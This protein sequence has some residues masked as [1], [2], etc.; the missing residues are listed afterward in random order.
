LAETIRFIE[1]RNTM[2][3]IKVVEE[4]ANELLNLMGTKAKAKVSEDKE[5]EA[6][7]VD[8]GASEEMGL[9][10]GHH[11]ET[12]SSFQ[13]LLGMILRQKTGE[14]TRVI[15]NVGDWR[16]KQEDYLRRLA[17]QTAQR[18]KETSQEQA[19]YNLSPSQR[20]IIHIAL[21]SDPDLETESLG[22]GK[23]RYLVIRLRKK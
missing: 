1:I 22:E 4:L 10:I 15:V 18:V 6:I 3:K 16:E 11:G 5:N 21:S 17:E 8:I 13:T 7:K 23:E 14:W 9:L 19:L 12:L 20:R 2:K